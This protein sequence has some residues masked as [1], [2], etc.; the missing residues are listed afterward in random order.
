MKTLA[1]AFL[2]ALAATGCGQDESAPAP[3]PDR[4]A[5][6]PAPDAGGMGAAGQVVAAGGDAGTAP[7]AD[8]GA[9]PAP[10]PDAMPE[11]AP[12]PAADAGAPADTTPA[13]LP[14]RTPRCGT[15]GGAT[16]YLIET[17]CSPTCAICRVE[18]ETTYIAG[19]FTAGLWCA[20]SC[21]QCSKEPAP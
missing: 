7:A 1:V 4:G 10:A 17:M 8:T 20:Q 3:A 11:P 13:P 5:E 19:C 18:G 9:A 2:L 21:S 12:V 14:D 16:H 15:N 6:L